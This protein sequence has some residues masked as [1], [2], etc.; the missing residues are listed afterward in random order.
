MYDVKV[1]KNRS[2]G[3]DIMIHVYLLRRFYKKREQPSPSSCQ[4]R[5]GLGINSRNWVPKV[6]NPQLFL[7]SFPGYTN[8]LHRVSSRS[9][10]Q[11][12]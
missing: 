6:V 7:P 11:D 1:Q 3:G 2:E 12:A 8:D 4:E 5:L 10:C 9:C